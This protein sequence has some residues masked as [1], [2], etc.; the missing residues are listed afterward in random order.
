[1]LLKAGA[2]LPSWLKAQWPQNKSGKVA[3]KSQIYCF[4]GPGACKNLIIFQLGWAWKGWYPPWGREVLGPNEYWHLL[5][6]N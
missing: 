3:E 4:V 6:I 2:L 5:G 1:M